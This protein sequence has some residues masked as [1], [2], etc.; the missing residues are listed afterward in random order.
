MKER[1]TVCR[2]AIGECDLPEFCNGKSEFCHADL[3]KRNTEDCGSGEYCF[4]GKCSSHDRRCKFLWGPSAIFSRDSYNQMDK[5]SYCGTLYCANTGT[6][7]LMSSMM[8]KRINSRR[9]SG[10]IIKEYSLEPNL[11]ENYHVAPNGD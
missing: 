6:F 8:G 1:G 4:D 7:Q 3:F 9:P 2:E 5:N 11:L 10:Y